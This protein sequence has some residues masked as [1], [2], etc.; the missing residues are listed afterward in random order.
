MS[1]VFLT[2]PKL[3]EVFCSKIVRTCEPLSVNG[4]SEPEKLHCLDMM[5]INEAIKATELQPLTQ[6]PKTAW[7]SR[8]QQTVSNARRLV[9]YF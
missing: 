1:A 2:A 6:Q 9:N 7:S 5:Q 8:G 4:A 3:P